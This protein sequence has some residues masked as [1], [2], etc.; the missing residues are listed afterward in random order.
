MLGN[1]IKAIVPMATAIGIFSSDKFISNETKRRFYEDES[2]ITPVPGTV[3]PAPATEVESLGE[4]T[5]I[6]GISVR[7]TPTVESSI[8]SIRKSVTSSYNTV[9]S[10]LNTQYAKLNQTEQAVTK[11]LGSLHS[12]SEDLLPNSIYIVVA[13]L[14]GTIFSRQKNILARL[15]FPIITGSLAFKYFLPNTFRNTT[16]FLWDL[17]RENVPVIAQHHEELLKNADDL[18]AQSEQ[19]IGEGRRFLENKSKAFKSAII[20]ITGLNVDEEVSKK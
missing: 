20:D 4:V 19:T 15:T 16:S 2:Q 12:R 9:K 1:T 14:S 11:R 18:V 6:D 17:E 10:E 8:K 13:A 7:T 3:T 5:L